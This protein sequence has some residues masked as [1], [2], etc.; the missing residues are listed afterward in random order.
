MEIGRQEEKK[1]HINLTKIVSK[2][3]RKKAKVIY[4]NTFFIF[5]VLASCKS[6]VFKLRN[7]LS[8][9]SSDFF[10]DRFC[11]QSA[12]EKIFY[13]EVQYIAKLYYS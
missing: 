10:V 2:G 3:V 4:E 5:S 8:L 9:D 1:K 11:G 7:Y 12:N 13:S 6:T